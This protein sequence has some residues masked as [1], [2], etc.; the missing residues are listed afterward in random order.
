[1]RART[2]S[3][4]LCL[5]ILPL[6]PIGCASTAEQRGGSVASKM[7]T[8]ASVGDKPLPVVTGEPG[9][10]VVAATDTETSVP[11]RRGRTE[12][13]ISGRIVD[14]NGEPVPF[15]RVRLAMGAAPGGKVIR[16]TTDRAGGFT[17]RGLRPGSSYTVIAESD[18]G[19]DVMTGR[20]VVRA[21][22]TD[23]QISLGPSEGAA[24][25][26][27]RANRVNPVSNRDGAEDEETVV[28]GRINVRELPPAPAAESLP[29]LSNRKARDRPTTAARS[30]S[31]HWRSAAPR[32]A[33]QDPTVPERHE[34]PAFQPAEPDDDD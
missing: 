31:A 28:P 25:S 23:V 26:A 34:R 15:A 11:D 14:D 5:L 12:G 13:R 6:A 17:L 7:R 4:S 29:P 21:P 22:D 1:M 16:A 33:G 18:D 2:L 20:S 19:A 9:N 24:R 32:V 8:V 10:A 3:R 27:N 30:S